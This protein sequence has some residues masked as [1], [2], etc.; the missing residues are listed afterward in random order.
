MSS[1]PLGK[2]ELTKY[3][4]KINIDSFKDKK[5]GEEIVSPKF[6]SSQNKHAWQL[7]LCP[8]GLFTVEESPEEAGHVALYLKHLNSNPINVDYSF[9]LLNQNYVKVDENFHIDNEYFDKGIVYGNSMFVKE[10]FIMDP[11]NNL[12]I[13]NNLSILCKLVT[14]DDEDDVEVLNNSTSR[15]IQMFDQFESLLTNKESSDITIMTAV[16]GQ[17]FHLH[18]C[19]LSINSPVFEAMFKNDMQEKIKNTVEIKDIRYDVLKEFFNFIYTGDADTWHISELLAAAEKYCV[20]HLKT[21]C[22]E[23]MAS[24]L[25]GNNFIEFLKE[26]IV[27]NAEK[28][29]AHIIKWISFQLECISRDPEFIEFGKQNPEVLLEIMQKSVY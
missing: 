10:S 5:I 14:C 27:N 28:L 16:K 24:T 2:L 4:W 18:K 26:A 8:K 23:S 6:F 15:K 13:D 11:E 1:G 7:E 25:C 29:K 20:L 17:H 9:S 21:F 3:I 19:I 22:E 12:T